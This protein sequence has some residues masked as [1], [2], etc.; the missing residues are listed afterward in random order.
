MHGT[1]LDDAAKQHAECYHKSKRLKKEKKK[2]R[3]GD[4]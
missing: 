2:A 3:E 4:R 1:H